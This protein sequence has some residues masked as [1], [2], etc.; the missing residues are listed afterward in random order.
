[1]SCLNSIYEGLFF[2]LD[3][4]GFFDNINGEKGRKKELLRAFPTCMTCIS[5][6][7]GGASWG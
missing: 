2:K 4:I 1:M 7:Y 3:V 6:S 5:I